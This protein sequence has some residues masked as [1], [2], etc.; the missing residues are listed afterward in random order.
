MPIKPYASPWLT[1]ELE[2][3]QDA[4]RRF[5]E[6]EFVPREA[7]WAKDMM[8]ERE[9][10]N[11]AGSMGLLCASIPE[12]YGGGGGTLAHRGRPTRQSGEQLFGGA[13]VICIFLVLE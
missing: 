5:F 7:R 2:M 4:A 6:A 8:M 12:Q 13:P 3:L 11:L 10:W 1:P 9:A